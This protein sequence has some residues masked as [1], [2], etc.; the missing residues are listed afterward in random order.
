MMNEKNALVYCCEK[1]EY[2]ENY[3]QAK[4]DKTTLYVIHHRLEILSSGHIISKQQLI[5]M[6]LY[7]NRPAAELIYMKIGD[8]AALHNKHRTLESKMKLKNTF[9]KNALLGK[10]KH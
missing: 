7:Y 1:P 3:Q 2:I 9:A 6:G 10:Y 5:N 8:H 4:E